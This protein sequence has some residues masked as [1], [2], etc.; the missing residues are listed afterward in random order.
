[1]AYVDKVKDHDGTVHSLRATIAG[2]TANTL[3]PGS[4]ATA[5]VGPDGGLVLGIPR[6]D[7]P[8]AGEDYWTEQDKRPIA[9]ATESARSAAEKAVTAASVAEKAAGV[10]DEAAVAASSVR[11]SGRFAQMDL[12]K[13]TDGYVN[14]DNG[15][16]D[17]A[18]SYS[19][20]D[21]I[22]LGTA[23]EY[24]VS[25]SY[26]WSAAPYGLY[27]V[28]KGFIAAPVSCPSTQV[29]SVDKIVVS[30]VLARY[31]NARYIRFSGTAPYGSSERVVVFAPKTFN[32]SGP[33]ITSALSS[34]PLYGKK[35]CACGDSFTEASNL[36]R[37]HY[38]RMTK[39][40]ASYAWQIAERNCMDYVPNAVSGSTMHVSDPEKPSDRSPFAY[41]R[42]KSVP[43]DA[44]Y[45]TIQFGLNEF[46]V[47]DS[48]ETLGTKE[49]VD[50]GTMW[51]SWNT[52]LGYLIENH[53][54]ARIG[55][56][57]SDAWLTEKYASEL[58]KIAEW[59]GVPVLD[60][61]GDP[62]VPVMNSGRRNGCGLELNPKVKELRDAQFCMSGSDTHPNYDG[63]AWRSTV[64]ENWMRGL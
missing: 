27:D 63:H 49:S 9:E 26:G 25:T 8:V 64:I 5:E 54:K 36:G 45:I 11:F 56:I 18:D 62:S 30:D 12:G 17:V 33:A 60:L 3:P 31:P 40:Y 10:A 35:Y 23:E 57:V 7:A 1:M 22:P 52:V 2:A 24:R 4:E 46:Q 39:S 13:M 43:L 28:D 47:A 58:K 6:G 20:T 14:K 44:D 48:P 16:I 59:W 32:G 37:E 38:D 34:N 19:V 51:G 21:F 55:I 61:G 53:P 42:Y 50:V 29:Y 15:R 41:E